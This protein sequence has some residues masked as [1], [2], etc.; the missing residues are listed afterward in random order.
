M[1]AYP[2]AKI[3]IGLR[4]TEKRQDGFHNLETVFFPVSLCD[5]L[6]IVEA[7][8]FSFSLY[9]M[10]PGGVKSENLCV[11]AYNLLRES[12]DLPPV[13]IHLFKKIPAGAGLG[14]GSSDASST[15]MLLNKLFKL[16]LSEHELAAFAA[17]LGSDCPFFIYSNG[18]DS[19]IPE[20]FYAE[21]RGDILSKIE[22]SSLKGYKIKVSTP[23]VSVSTA[24][25]Y[26]IVKPF[27]P[28]NNL[29]KII[30]LS[31]ELWTGK[32][33]ND[34]EEGVFKK[35]PIIQEYKKKMYE[36]GAVYASMS[37]SGS[38]VF[39]IFRDESI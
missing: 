22:I 9:G 15:L 25:A 6:E 4:I 11:R 8:E 29:V 14:G 24:F 7:P 38:S 2:K 26:S 12:I 27:K 19:S 16:G 36:D 13:E 17:K 28:N 34:F 5:I 23:P 32:V 20:A 18:L 39:G 37:G 1:I 31:P 21:G 33:V 35:F 30:E 3:N 10:D